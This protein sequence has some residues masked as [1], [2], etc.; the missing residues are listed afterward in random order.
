MKAV[1]K[2]VPAIVIF[3]IVAIGVIA[4]SSKQMSPSDTTMKGNDGLYPGKIKV[5]HLVALDMAPLF[6]AK[7]AGFFEDEG[8]DVDL[9][10]FSNP[11]DNNAALAGGSVQFNINPF[12]LPYFGENSGVPMRI[13]STAGGLEII[14]VVMQGQYEVETI[15]QLAEWVKNNPNQTL[16]VGTLRGDTLDM[17]LYRSF[18]EAGLTYDDFEMIW[19]NDLLAM[20]ESFR[21]GDIAILSHI[22]PY[23]TDLIVNYDA[24]VL[25]NN[26]E[27]WGKG[28]PNTTIVVLED[29][30]AQ[31]PETVRRYLRATYK[32]FELI[33]NNPEQ[34]VELLTGGNYYKIDN[35][36]LLYALKNQPKE[37]L[38]HPNVDGMM[39]AIQDMV[40]Q[41]YIEQ[42]QQNI[43][44]T[45]ILD[46]VVRELQ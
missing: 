23:T 14:Q 34:A 11:G 29:F 42:P 6:V 37:V 43:V 24:K 36:V 44:K 27:V 38:L 46:A 9:A 2:F 22:K 28:T 32:G 31:Y 16:K 21:T 25:T 41:N 45:D 26:D 15:K 12:T 30:L 33:V 35:D 20:V 3:T 7:E 10:F 5:G 40:Q 17:I 39:M 1:N 13:I 18:A 8:L 4:F 19:F